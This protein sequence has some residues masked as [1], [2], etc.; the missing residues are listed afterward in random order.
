MTDA[1]K[2]A[3]ELVMERLRKKDAESGIAEPKLSDEQKA[4]IAEA[5]SV[6]EARVAERQILQRSKVL[7]AADSQEREVLEEQYRRDLDRF[8]SD[9]DAKIRKIREQVERIVS[10]RPDVLRRWRP[11][12]QRMRDADRQSRTAQRSSTGIRSEGLERSQ[13]LAMFATLTDQIGPRLTGTPAHKQAAEWA[14]DRLRAFG[15]ATRRWSRGASVAAGC[16]TGSWWRWSSLATCRSSAT[17]KPGRHRP[18]ARSPRT[19]V[20]IGGRTPA[21]VQAMRDELRGAIVMSQ[22]PAEFIR[23]DRPQ[24][25]TVRRRRSESAL[26]P[27]PVRAPSAGRR[28]APSASR[29]TTPAPASSCAPALESM[30][31][32]S[33]SVATRLTRLFRR[34]CS[35]A[36]TTT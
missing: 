18:T 15:L 1:P 34:S 11:C 25:T 2:S 8:A 33:C 4:A 13:V 6:Y 23:A 20:M 24:P 14:R 9:R 35:P 28:S 10:A 22:P 32:S 30:A 5:R 7:V 12:R 16:S 36:S 27:I 31:P 3:L 17:P 21:E 26:R 29:F 19:P